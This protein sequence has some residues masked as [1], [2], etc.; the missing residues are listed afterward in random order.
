MQAFFART[1]T[2]QRASTVLR[3][4]DFSVCLTQRC[5]VE[6]GNELPG[7]ECR[8]RHCRLIAPVFSE[9]TL[10]AN[11]FGGINTGVSNSL[12]LG[13][14]S[15]SWLPWGPNVILGL[16]KCN[17]SLTRGRSSA[18]PPG[19]NK[20]PGWIKQGGGPDLAWGLCVC[21]LWINRCKTVRAFLIATVL[22]FQSLGRQK[23]M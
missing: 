17:Y 10:D 5:L 4:C 6:G 13:A 7:Q 21:H 22:S 1:S 9:G 23:W 12:S 2:K 19:R 8:D 16:Y 3:H 14:T 15:A 20:V 11:N 18:L